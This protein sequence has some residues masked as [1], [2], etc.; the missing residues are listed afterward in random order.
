MSK[1]QPDRCF[2]FSSP[3]LQFF[4]LFTIQIIIIVV[5]VVNRKYFTWSIL[6]EA[7]EWAMSRYTDLLCEQRLKALLDNCYWKSKIMRDLTK[8]FEI[9]ETQ[10][11]IEISMEFVR[12]SQLLELLLMYKYSNTLCNVHLY[13]SH[14]Y[15]H[16]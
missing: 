13:T 15:A 14:I 6:V 11:T 16:K 3:S 9:N 12:T 5:V 8:Y 7:W 4:I 2:F 10:R 1:Y